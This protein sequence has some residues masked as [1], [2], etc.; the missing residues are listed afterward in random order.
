MNGAMEDMLREGLDRLTAQ[1][2]VPAGVTGRA[3]ARLR[4]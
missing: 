2:Q 4:R 3:R 1:V